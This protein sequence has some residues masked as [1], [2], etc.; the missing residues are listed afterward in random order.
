MFAPSDMM[1]PVFDDFSN[2]LLIA[3]TEIPVLVAISAIRATCQ[4]R[5]LRDKRPNWMVLPNCSKPQFVFA[6][7]LH[8]EQDGHE[9]FAAARENVVN[10]RRNFAVVDAFK[11]AVVDKLAELL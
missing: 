4:N 9:A 7:L 8:S 5:P 10:A 2:A 11:E 1:M 3:L 6:P